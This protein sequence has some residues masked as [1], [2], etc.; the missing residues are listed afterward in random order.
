MALGSYETALG[1]LGS[2]NRKSSIRVLSDNKQLC[3][4]KLEILGGS[5]SLSVMQ[6]LSCTGK[7]DMQLAAAC[8]EAKKGLRRAA[9]AGRLHHQDR[10]P[11]HLHHHHPT[12]HLLSYRPLHH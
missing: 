9:G 4:G 7:V 11:C 6:V 1:W 2:E 10:P 5:T 8:A 12:H 3:T